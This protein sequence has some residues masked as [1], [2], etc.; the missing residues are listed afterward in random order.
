MGDE[1]GWGGNMMKYC[2]SCQC[3][4]FWNRVNIFRF[5]IVFKVNLSHFLSKQQISITC[6]YCD[7][8][9]TV[10]PLKLEHLA[11]HHVLYAVLKYTVTV[12]VNQDIMSVPMLDPCPRKRYAKSNN[13]GQTL[14]LLNKNL[15]NDHKIKWECNASHKCDA[16]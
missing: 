14:S 15:L 10:V 6:Q 3:S 1:W 11:A 2:E 7:Q 13:F 8:T 4:N 5:Q 9:I 16:V 12:L